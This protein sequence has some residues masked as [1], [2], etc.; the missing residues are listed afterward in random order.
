MIANR[1]ENNKFYNKFEWKVTIN[2]I[3]K[4]H[5][6][7]S[8]LVKFPFNILEYILIELDK[9]SSIFGSCVFLSKRFAITTVDILNPSVDKERLKLEP[10]Q[11]NVFY[12]DKYHEVTQILKFHD[13]MN[14]S[15][16]LKRL[17][18]IFNI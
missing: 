1:L 15:S 9:F 17:L 13:Q 2:S 5:N 16:L 6:Y 10:K 11:V 18:N 3:K 12:K 14:Y 8:N 4:I 7:D